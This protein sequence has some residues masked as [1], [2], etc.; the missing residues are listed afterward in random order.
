[1]ITVKLC[2]F[3]S[4]SSKDI[5]R[6]ISLFL[7]INH[8]FS[9]HFAALYFVVVVVTG[10]LMCDLAAIAKTQHGKMMIKSTK[11]KQETVIQ[12]LIIFLSSFLLF[13]QIIHFLASY[14]HIPGF[15]IIT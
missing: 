12:K 9:F 6:I 8:S 5:K 15:K 7:Y 2:I 3:F 14:S 10:H 13:C 1:M 4:S 11:K